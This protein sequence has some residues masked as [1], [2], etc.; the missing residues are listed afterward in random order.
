MIIDL[1]YHHVGKEKDVT[2]KNLVS[3][4]G[5]ISSTERMAFVGIGVL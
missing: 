1:W 3:C 4:V 5:Q 2:I